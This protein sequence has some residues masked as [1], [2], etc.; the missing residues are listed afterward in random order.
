MVQEKISLG[1]DNYSGAHPSIIE[2][3]S[4]ANTPFAP[5][6]GE[7]RWTEQAAKLISQVFKKEAT[8][9]FLPTGTGA[10]VLALKIA[11]RRHESV[12]CTDVAHINL[13][14]CGAAESIVG[15][16]LLAVPSN[17]GKL[18]L[19]ELD[20]KLQNERA[21]GKH[22]TLPRLVSITQP[23]DSGTLYTIAE[24]KALA[25]FCQKEKLLLHIDGSRLYNAAVALNCSLDEIVG[26]SRCDLLSLGGTKNGLVGAE[27]LVIFN[28]ALLPGSDHIHKQTLQLLSK[29]RYLSAQYL[30]FF[31]G[32]LWRELASNAN[33][34]AQEIASIIKATPGFTLSYPVETNQIFFTLP[35]ELI[36]VVQEKV[37]CYLWDLERNE[38]RFVTSWNTQESDVEAV[39]TL[40]KTF[41]R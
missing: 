7:D 6:Y 24:L 27:A 17:R 20:R 34:R 16:K 2:A 11:L 9:Y 23:T 39:R 31:K 22:S 18:D 33:Q 37:W 41:N 38:I 21:S 4:E 5:A 26:A 25:E 1:S 36:K 19:R 32:D 14:E 40:F 30:A 35:R 10:N 12:L 29:M 13:Q 8:T 15:C 3:I 28:R